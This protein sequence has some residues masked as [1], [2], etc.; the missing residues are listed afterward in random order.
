VQTEA[1]DDVFEK[2]NWEALKRCHCA[3]MLKMEDCVW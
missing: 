2:L 1:S 3:A